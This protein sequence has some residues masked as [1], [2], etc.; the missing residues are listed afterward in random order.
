V[1]DFTLEGVLASYQSSLD[2]LGT[3]RVELLLA[4]D[5][6]KLTHGEAAEEYT[7][8]FLQGGYKALCQL[9]AEGRIDLIGIGVNEVDI[10]HRLL[11]EVALD[12]I[13]LAGRY[14]L[15]EQDALPLLDRCA[16][17][18]VRVIVGG[19][20]NSG[21]LVENPESGPLHYDYEKAPAR[22][23]SRVASLRSICA[24]YATPLPAAALRFPLGHP[25]VTC[26]LPGFAGPAQVQQAAA[27]NKTSIPAA[28]WP[29]LKHAELLA[30][31]APYPGAQRKNA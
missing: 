22:L 31:D 29:A 26:V 8:Q 9:K 7:Q 11:D 13:L 23:V 16:H 17:L 30:P 28:L 14:T 1:F 20:F 25:A 27:W 12:A 19:P 24:E 5:L 6:G 4:H 3:A 2:R 15:L 21:L 18:G 10:C